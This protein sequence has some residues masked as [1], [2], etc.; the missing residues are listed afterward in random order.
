MNELMAEGLKR[1]DEGLKERMNEWLN[2]WK[3]KL[4]YMNE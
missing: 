4:E 1:K 2:K 3:N